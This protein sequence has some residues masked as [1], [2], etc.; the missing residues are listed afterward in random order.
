MLLYLNKAENVSAEKPEKLWILRNLD[1]GSLEDNVDS[2]RTTI[3]IDGTS[4]KCELNPNLIPDCHELFVQSTSPNRKLSAGPVI[5]RVASEVNQVIDEDEDMPVIKRSIVKKRGRKSLRTEVEVEEVDGE[6]DTEIGTGTSKRMKLVESSDEWSL[7]TAFPS[8]VRLK[9]VQILKTEDYSH[10]ETGLPSSVLSTLPASLTSLKLQGG[11]HFTGIFPPLGPL[12]PNLVD[13]HLG[14]LTFEILQNL[15]STLCHLTF[16]SMSDWS[17]VT[18][19]VWPTDL[20]SLTCLWKNKDEM[21]L[22]IQSLVCLPRHVEALN[23]LVPDSLHHYNLDGEHFFGDEDEDEE[24]EEDED[25]EEDGED[26]EKKANRA[27]KAILAQAKAVF[28]EWDSNIWSVMKNS[29][30]SNTMARMKSGEDNILSVEDYDIAFGKGLLYG[31]PVGLKSLDL[32]ALEIGYMSVY[33]LPPTLTYARM[34]LTEF[35]I[36]NMDFWQFLPPSLTELRIHS[37]LGD[38]SETREPEEWA[39]FSGDPLESP[40][41]NHPNLVSLEISGLTGIIPIASYLPRNLENLYLRVVDASFEEDW[42]NFPSTLQLLEIN[43][44]YS[45]ESDYSGECWVSYLPRGLKHLHNL[46]TYDDF[47]DKVLLFSH[48]KDLPPTLETFTS[49]VGRD[50]DHSNVDDDD[51]EDKFIKA[52]KNALPSS[53]RHFTLLTEREDPQHFFL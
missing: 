31:L 51:D 22:R 41:R 6:N 46:I 1:D 17:K 10:G 48:L 47:L 13:L 37:S 52:I 28:D 35:M 4:K 16:E 24:D 8:L 33:L 34:E 19:S 9:L 20:V 30:V 11:I 39:V 21:E 5:V 36:T 27:K 7:A 49:A 44:P 45:Y 38:T 18:P 2:I 25:D 42:K 14:R 53:V 32:A 50:L 3:G 23:I 12:L 29:M 43:C 40:L 15:P 26:D